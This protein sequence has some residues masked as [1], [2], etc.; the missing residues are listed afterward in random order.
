MRRS[1]TITQR[2]EGHFQIRYNL[3]ID[4]LT[5]I[6]QRA[7]VSI[8]GT[9]KQA[10]RKLN[11]LLDALECGLNPEP[12]K[13]NVSDFLKQWLETI[14]AQVSPRTHERYSEI[15]NNFLIPSFGNCL[16]TKLTPS[17]IQQV[18][19]KWE[20]SGRRDKKHGGL[21][22]RSRLHIHRIFKSALKYALQLQIIVRNPADAVKPPKVKKVSITV[23]TV[24]QSTILLKSLEETKLYWAVL[25]ALT[26]GMRR[27]EILALRWRNV[28]FGKKTIR[29]VES[30]E[31]TK[32]RLRF[33]APKT[34]K[35]RAVLLPDYAVEK[36]RTWKEEQAKQLAAENITQ[37]NDTLV[38]GRWDG[39]PVH[40]RTITHKFMSAIRRLPDLPRVRFHDLRHSH[41]TQLLTAGIHPKIA[42][43]RLG[44]SSI[45]TT[46]D[47]YSHV[48]DT[49][50]DEAASKLDE[51]FRSAANNKPSPTQSPKL[52]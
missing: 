37:T 27:G 41:A 39:E 25:L 2:S 16:L 33:K 23:L 32:N 9:R 35:T 18:Y 6:R 22:P 36:L 30:L 17:A 10:E 51:A 21:S 14:H 50:Q 3:G 24:E 44:H 15:V 1:G 5:G 8:K 48:T 19:N 43:E 42:Q 34:E 4:P 46:L 49:M 45:M 13:V 47:L 38:C 28:D 11:E 20:T 40:P 31:Q 29:V 7:A 12:T 26:T 52:G